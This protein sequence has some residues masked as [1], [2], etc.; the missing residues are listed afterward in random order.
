MR[1]TSLLISVIASLFATSAI[2][3]DLI[4]S[5][6]GA[7]YCATATASSLLSVESNARLSDLVVQMM[8]ES[9]GVSKDSRWANSSRPVFLWA[10]EA[11]LA[12]GKAYGYLRTDYRDDE[13]LNKCECFYNRMHEYMN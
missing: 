3:A 7:P 6:T 1:K 10:K 8:D 9:T 13:N 5:E 11:S 2:A 12:C 4:G